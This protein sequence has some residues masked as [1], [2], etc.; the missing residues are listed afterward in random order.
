MESYLSFSNLSNGEYNAAMEILLLTL[1]ILYSV[2]SF[3]ILNYS[4][5]SIDRMLFFFMQNYGRIWHYAQIQAN[6]II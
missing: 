1:K 4:F 3:T 2:Y 5:F 6:S